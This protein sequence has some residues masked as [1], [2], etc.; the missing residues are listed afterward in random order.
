MSED[1]STPA[2]PEAR[3][4]TYEHDGKVYNLGELQAADY[5]ALVEWAR[6]RYVDIA[7]AQIA[8]L[9]AHVGG[10]VLADVLF[11][12]ACLTRGS[13]EFN[14]IVTTPEGLA[15]LLLARM[16]RAEQEHPAP[17]LADLVDSYG[18]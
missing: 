10:Q 17:K 7:R 11:K 6:S 3:P 14:A 5:A 16:G 4:K 1:A 9:P 2:T 18:G 15:R 13:H 12:A 8:R